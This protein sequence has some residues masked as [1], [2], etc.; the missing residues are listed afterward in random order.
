MSCC[1]QRCMSI[2]D[3]LLISLSL[4]LYL[5]LLPFNCCNIASR[6]CHLVKRV[7]SVVN[8]NKQISC[9]LVKAFHV[10]NKKGGQRYDIV[11]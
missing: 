1:G 9:A 7:T 2:A 6:Q 10:A 5:S 11:V 4:L 3:S 8:R